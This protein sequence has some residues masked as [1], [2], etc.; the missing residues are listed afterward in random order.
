MLQLEIPSFEL[1]DEDKNEYIYV[2][3]QTL[4]LEH[5]L[6]SI[7][8]WESKWNVPYLDSKNHTHEQVM[9][10]IKCMTIT[11]N[12]NDNIY[13]YMPRSCINVIEEYINLPMSATKFVKLSEDEDKISSSEIITA[14]VIYYWMISLN[15]PIEFQKWPINRLLTL[16][17]V[18]NLKNGTGKKKKSKSE[19][20]KMYH[21][22]N[23][24]RR[25]KYNSK[26]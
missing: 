12:V 16:I 26:G 13:K 18:F 24:E 5:S 1:Y 2:K 4:Q 23:A 17:R 21:E 15:I 19:L 8:K 9:D 10:Y 6:V 3:G 22:I 20:A 11:Q 7:A 14:E 25:K